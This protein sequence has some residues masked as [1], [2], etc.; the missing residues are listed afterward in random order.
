VAHGYGPLIPLGIGA[1][2]GWRVF[3]QGGWLDRAD[4]PSKHSYYFHG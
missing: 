3:R 1:A 4:R 2:I